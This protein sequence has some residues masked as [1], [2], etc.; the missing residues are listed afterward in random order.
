MQGLRGPL[1]IH[2]P[3]NEP[4]TSLYDAEIIVTLT[5]WFHE[6]K[7]TLLAQWFEVNGSGNEPLPDSALINGI[8][9]YNCTAAAKKPKVLKK[10]GY[11]H[12]MKRGLEEHGKKKI[13][14]VASKPKP[15][16]TST[17]QYTTFS[18][19]PGKRY[20]F[21]VINMSAM[22]TFTFSIDGHKMDV[23][24]ADGV[25]TIKT[26][27]DQVRINTAQRCK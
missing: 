7:N 5:D 8:G 27:V 3:A 2:D 24:E 16:C 25:D 11:H 14:K 13:A 15:A 1:I 21:R 6:D 10:L 22:S 19:T 20:R 17:P 18:V 9:Q 23:I 12:M 26:T 4:Y